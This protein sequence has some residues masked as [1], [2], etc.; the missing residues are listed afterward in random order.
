MNLENYKSLCQRT[1]VIT[2]SILE[3]TIAEV[4]KSNSEV[5]LRLHTILM[6]QP[7]PK[8]EEQMGQ[9]YMDYFEISLT[10][11]EKLAVVQCLLKSESETAS[12][13]ASLLDTWNAMTE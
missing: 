11:N 3:D 2:R 8:P 1:D 7:I 10:D 4:R 12:W 13:H 9:G 5:A 6:G